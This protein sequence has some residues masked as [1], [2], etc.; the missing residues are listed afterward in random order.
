MVR[1]PKSPII[2]NPEVLPNQAL[3]RPL[4]LSMLFRMVCRQTGNYPAAWQS[5]ARSLFHENGVFGKLLPGTQISEK[6]VIRPCGSLLY[7]PSLGRSPE[8]WA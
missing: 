3:W 2:G 1:F 7:C 5:E 6:P 8:D 4:G